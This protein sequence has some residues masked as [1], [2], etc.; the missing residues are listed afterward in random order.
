MAKIIDP[1]ELNQ[2]TEV[3]IDTTGKT[4]QLVEAG[5][6]DNNS[7]GATSG[8]T[9]QALYSFLKEE[10][11]TDTALNKFKFPLKMYTKTDGTFINGWTFEDAA[12]RALV[13]DAGW[14]E[15]TDI[16]A[17]IVSLGNFD[18]TT[19]QAYYSQTQGYDETTSNFDK[20]GNLNEAI[21]ITGVTSYLKCFL[22]IS[23]G[24]GTGKLYSEYDLLTEQS[25][26]TLEPVL[27]KLPLSNSP[28][29][30]TSATDAV[31]DAS[32]PYT[33]MKINYLAGSGF[34]TW[35]NSHAYPAGSVVKSLAGRWYF[36]AAGGTS[37]GTDVADDSGV[38]DWAVYDGEVQIG[39][40]YYAF[41]RIIT[42]NNGTDREIY[43]WAQ[44]NLR[45]STDINAD[46]STTENQ[47]SGLVM[48]G[49][50][51]E[52]L[53]EYVGDTLKTKGGVYISGFNSDSTNNII[54]RD[55]TVDSGGVDEDTYLPTVSTELWYPYVSTGNLV[56]S[57]NLTDESDADTLYTM[58]FA[59]AGGNLF[60]S[61]NAIIVKDNSNTD[62][63][64]QITASSIGW[65]FDYD[66]NAQGG[67]TPATD[68]AVV[69]V[70]QGLEGATW[71]LVNYT[72]TRSAGQTIT[73][74]ADDERNYA[75]P[76]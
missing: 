42:G 40:G 16:Y 23:E 18:A 27:Y 38:T 64:G 75:N 17:G 71:V 3:I 54:F 67:R 63:K 32:G 22:R 11:K 36:T 53:V 62:I 59:N 15:G 49:T 7:P 20:T 51:A 21:N 24:D 41:N 10:W 14:T 31:I 1:D 65:T 35:A 72:I 39:T 46:D 34:T 73:I 48:Y 60:D 25:I 58:Y 37:S 29:L 47:R 56:F 45:K 52:L 12:S 44:R 55:I 2:G 6:L 66:N 9:L 13:R 43:D 26:A 74:N 68:A 70:A 28:D 50:L 33:G 19:D 69:V 30:K 61:A 5:N 57:S 8:V 4:I 76:A